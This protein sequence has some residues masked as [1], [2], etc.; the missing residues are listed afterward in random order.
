MN[1]V[2]ERKASFATLDNAINS[3][4][5]ELDLLQESLVEIQ[6]RLKDALDL[7]DLS[8]NSAYE[9]AKDEKTRTLK[10][11]ANIQAF[12]DAYS[13]LL[14]TCRK[15]EKIYETVPEEERT[16]RIG[17]FIKLRTEDTGKI[18]NFILVPDELGE[19]LI[20]VLSVESYQGRAL[21]GK[22]VN[23]R[24]RVKTSVGTYEVTILNIC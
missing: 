9:I 12:L 16:C 24:V 21:S 22:K 1:I 7:G 6:T 10:E 13:N 5:K 17:S 3:K 20:G 14:E 23:D 19:A 11:K 2:E 8:E 18:Y 15:L 4:R